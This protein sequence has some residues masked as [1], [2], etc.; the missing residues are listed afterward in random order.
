MCAC[1]LKQAAN[2]FARDAL[3]NALRGEHV[4]EEMLLGDLWRPCTG[5]PADEDLHPCTDLPEC[6]EDNW[7]HIA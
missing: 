1:A 6:P 5:Q 4:V 7:V 3:R 2:F